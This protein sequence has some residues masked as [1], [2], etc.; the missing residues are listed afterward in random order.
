MAG[1]SA[2]W[3]LVAQAA[4]LRAALIVAAALLAASLAA[5][6]RWPLSG[7]T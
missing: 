3:G 7:V 6:R 5:A 1:G 4:G 2:A